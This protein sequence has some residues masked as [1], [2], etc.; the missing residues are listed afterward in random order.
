MSE[1]ATSSIEKIL[2]LSAL[3]LG[4]VAEAVVTPTSYFSA[5]QG[6]ELNQIGGI[7]DTLRHHKQSITSLPYQEEVKASAI[8]YFVVSLRSVS[9]SEIPF[10]LTTLYQL[11]DMYLTSGVITSLIHNGLNASIPEGKSV[12]VD[13]LHAPCR[14]VDVFSRLRRM[15]I[16]LSLR[17]HHEEHLIIQ[18]SP[19]TN[20]IEIHIYSP[21]HDRNTSIKYGLPMLATETEG[22]FDDITKLITMFH[23]YDFKSITQWANDD[24]CWIK[25]QINDNTRH[26]QIVD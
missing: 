24:L 18:Q 10:S 15:T 19:K 9:D 5:A 3:H 26:L 21:V 25:S 17:C 20:E 12:C 6:S 7:A 22:E 11:S 14:C 13:T 4:V 8:Q 2:E 1:E 16:L 23:L